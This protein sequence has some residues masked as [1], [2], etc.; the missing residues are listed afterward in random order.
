MRCITQT[1]VN[2]CETNV[3]RITSGMVVVRLEDLP[4]GSDARG[5]LYAPFAAAAA[6]ASAAG[7]RML[8]HS[9]TGHKPN[10]GYRAMTPVVVRLNP[11]GQPQWQLSQAQGT[12]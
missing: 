6:S 2:C 10:A 5:A 1:T 11:Q 8:K 7:S 12:R 9:K 4:L 3:R